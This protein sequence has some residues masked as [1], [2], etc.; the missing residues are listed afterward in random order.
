MPSVYFVQ[1]FVS[2]ML[3]SKIFVSSY[4][5]V[6]GSVVKGFILAAIITVVCFDFVVSSVVVCFVIVV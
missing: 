4:V 5:V 3:L 1:A 2:T 6:L